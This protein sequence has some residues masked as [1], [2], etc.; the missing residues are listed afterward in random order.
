MHL[1]FFPRF[2]HL[3]PCIYLPQPNKFFCVLYW[4]YS[5]TKP[6]YNNCSK[7]FALN[8]LK[9][10]FYA[11]LDKRNLRSAMCYSTC[12]YCISH[13]FQPNQA[14]KVSLKLQ[15]SIPLRSV[16]V[17]MTEPIRPLL[18]MMLTFF[19][20]LKS[21]GYMCNLCCQNETSVT[22]LANN[23]HLKNKHFRT[24]VC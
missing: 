13:T 15:K 6:K 7:R 18:E 21:S 12:M 9:I 14:P 22:K 24:L 11:L 5:P 10:G 8:Q 20:F 1:S 3:Q 23:S 16:N 2:F 19:Q 4:K 17:V